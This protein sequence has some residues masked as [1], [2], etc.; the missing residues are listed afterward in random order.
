M[1][2]RKLNLQFFWDDVSLRK[3]VTNTDDISAAFIYDL[4]VK[5]YDAGVD[6][7]TQSSKTS[8]YITGSNTTTSSY[9][10]AWTGSGDLFIGGNNTTPFSANKL[11]GSLMEFRL[12][13]EPLEEDIF[14]KHVSN[15]KS[16]IGNTPSSSYYNLV[17]EDF[18]LMI[19]QTL[20]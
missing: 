20:L 6:R 7:I 8:L 12:W 16:Y 17:I 4:F 15:P 18:H 11:S 10:A 5:K 2:I 1:K 19:I 13:T 3:A 14:D 9:N